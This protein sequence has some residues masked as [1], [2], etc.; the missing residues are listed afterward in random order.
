[1]TDNNEDTN[2]QQYRFKLTTQNV[3]NQ[4][5]ENPLRRCNTNKFRNTTKPNRVEEE[6]TL[7]QDNKTASNRDDS[8]VKILLFLS[9]NSNNSSCR[10]QEIQQ[11]NICAL[12]ESGSGQVAANQKKTSVETAF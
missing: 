1:M 3:V 7:I 12:R 6:T 10:Q 4:K 11:H 5:S 9:F 2:R 8:S